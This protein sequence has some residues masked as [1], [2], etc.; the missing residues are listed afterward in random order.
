[1]L[2]KGPARE[3]VLQHSKSFDLG[4]GKRSSGKLLLVALTSLC[5]GLGTKRY[6]ISQMG[7]FKAHVHEVVFR[8]I[9]QTRD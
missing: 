3:T 5:R 8:D 1:M 2:H 6:G 9:R 4:N 7:S